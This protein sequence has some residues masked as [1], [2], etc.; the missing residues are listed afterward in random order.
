MLEAMDVSPN[1]KQM[2]NISYTTVLLS[3]G[4][5][6]IPALVRAARAWGSGSGLEDI[7]GCQSPLQSWGNRRA[8]GDMLRT[9]GSIALGWHQSHLCHAAVWWYFK[10][11]L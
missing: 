6:S 8:G 4:C 3:N 1:P 5:S 11:G 9:K 10:A 7:V 2:E